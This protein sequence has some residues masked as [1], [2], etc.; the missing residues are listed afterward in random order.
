MRLVI[1]NVILDILNSS[2]LYKTVKYSFYKEIK[3]AAPGGN[4]VTLETEFFYIKMNNEIKLRS[5]KDKIF[6]NIGYF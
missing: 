6:Q 2:H 3:V 5:N 1:K 4:F